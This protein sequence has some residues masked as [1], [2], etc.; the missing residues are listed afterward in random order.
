MKNKALQNSKKFDEIYTPLNALEYLIPWLKP[1]STIF[2]PC[3]GT[4][5]LI[6][7]FQEKEFKT[8]GNKN[9]DYFNNDIKPEMY[10]YLITNPP[11]SNKRKFIKHAIDWL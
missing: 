10:D 8:I 3:Y 6:R 9:I 1:N 7:F 4:G 2:E 5:N 11:Y